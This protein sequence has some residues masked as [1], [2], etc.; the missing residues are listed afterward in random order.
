LR[1]GELKVKEDR[2]VQEF[3]DVKRNLSAVNRL[4]AGKA[5]LDRNIEESVVIGMDVEGDRGGKVGTAVE[6]DVGL[7]EVLL[8]GMPIWPAVDF[9]RVLSKNLSFRTACGAPL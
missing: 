8:S 6:E 3:L 1:V 9:H 4:V 5:N 7:G 2:V